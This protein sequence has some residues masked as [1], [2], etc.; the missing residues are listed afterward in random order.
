MLMRLDKILSAAGIASRSGSKAL[1][2]A[3]RVT[4]NGAPASSGA[5]KCDPATCEIRVDGAPVASRETYYLMRKTTTAY[6]S[7]T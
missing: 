5:G 2:R 6:F 3:G 7:E 4:V 1:F